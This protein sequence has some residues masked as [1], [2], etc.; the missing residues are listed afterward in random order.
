VLALVKEDCRR[1]EFPF[2]RPAQAANEFARN[3]LDDYTPIIFHK[4]NHRPLF[5]PES[6]A[7]ASGNDELPLGLE[8]P[9]KFPGGVGQIFGLATVLMVVS[10]FVSLIACVNI[11]NPLLARDTSWRA[12]RVDPM[13]ALR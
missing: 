6:P 10:G 8:N 7:R 3:G 13:V 9:A 12:L 11:A 4:G 5:D 1:R 2:E